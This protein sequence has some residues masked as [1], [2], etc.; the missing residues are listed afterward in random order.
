[1]PPKAAPDET[2]ITC[3]PTSG[4]RNTP[5]KVAPESARP[6]PESSASRMRGMRTVKTTFA[7]VGVTGTSGGKIGL[8]RIC[9]TRANAMS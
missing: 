5:C 8:Q 9:T 6:A 2:P 4:L 7:S 3:G 1:V